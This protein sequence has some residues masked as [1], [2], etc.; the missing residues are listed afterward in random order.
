[1]GPKKQGLVLGTKASSDSIAA[2]RRRACLAAQ[3]EAAKRASPHYPATRGRGRVSNQICGNAQWKRR[4]RYLRVRLRNFSFA[5]LTATG[6]SAP[7]LGARVNT[8]G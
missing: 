7:S 5:R 6:I 1:M 2:P 8:A 4:W 3:I